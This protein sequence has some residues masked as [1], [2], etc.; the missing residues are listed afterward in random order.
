MRNDE[1]AMKRNGRQQTM[2]SGLRRTLTA[3]GLAAVP[4]AFPVEAMTIYVSNEKGNSI[5]VIDGDS[6]EVAATVDVGNRP[7]G[8]ALSKDHRFLYICAWSWSA[9]CPPAPIRS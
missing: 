7:R 4:F 5:T 3:F 2:H 6:M 1:R 8:I 9:P